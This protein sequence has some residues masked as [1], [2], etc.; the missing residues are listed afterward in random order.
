M[1]Q[2]AQGTRP[3]QATFAGWLII[4]GSIILLF[5][6]WQRIS[7]LNSLEMQEQLRT[8]LAE[9]PL[10]GTGMTVSDL[11]TLVR[12]ASLAA[13][14]AATAAAIL[15]FHA[16]QRSAGARLGLTLLAPVVLV[17]G[18]ATGGFFAPLVV[19]GVVMLWLTPTRDWFAGRPWVNQVVPRAADPKRP[20]PFAHER[21]DRPPVPTDDQP[22]PPRASTVPFGQRAASSYRGPEQSVRGPR[23]AAVTW[24]CGLVWVMSGL[25]A[26]LMMLTALVLVV[27]SEEFFDELE[28]QQPGLNLE[29]LS[30]T[31]VTIGIVV[32]AGFATLWCITASVLAIFA[33]RGHNWARIAVLV[34]SIATGA[35][36]LPAMLAN[37]LLVVVLAAAAASAGL[38]L[39]PDV[40]EWYRT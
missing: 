20:D 12:V 39:R 14:G 1:S 22:P 3:G 19:A 30:D 21:G 35:V 6:A 28:R 31:E 40:A 17:G 25:V 10:S 15:G 16:L 9:P 11:T 7:G 33:F 24:A 37:P 34:S 36:C 27:A 18:F 8:A 26:S 13:G 29:G 2:D 32:V 38:L 4:G 5:S 23:P